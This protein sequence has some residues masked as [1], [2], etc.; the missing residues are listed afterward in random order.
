MRILTAVGTRP[1]LV[2][3]AP[4]S[5]ALRE[6]GHE[7]IL[8]HTGQHY[9]GALT[10]ILPEGAGLPAPAVSLGVGSGSHGA[11]VAAAARGIAEHAARLLPDAVLVAGDTN[12]ALAAALG[13]RAA[14]IPLVHGEA[15]VRLGS[16]ELP[17]EVNRIAADH[18]ADLLLAPTAR[19]AA[20][21]RAEKPRGRTVDAGDPLLDALGDVASRGEGTVAFEP[22]PGEFLLA[23]VHRA[24][25]TDRPGRLAAL[26][27]DLDALRFPVLL[28]LHPRT[29]EAMRAGGAA[30]AEGG[31]L[32]L[33][34]PMPHGALLGLARRARAVVTD[35]GGLQREAFWLGVPCVVLR[36]RCEWTETVEAGWAVLAGG[37]GA[38]LRAAVEAPPRGESAPDLGAFGGGTAASRWVRAMEEFLG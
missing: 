16:L 19:A 34:E 25:N 30:P 9:D 20:A 4:V 28:P 8:L 3:G 31:S 38:D 24:E 2:R 29:R 1:Q 10:A 21:A 13:A 37:G 22:P 5:R 11:Q 14:G 17:E 33:L 6:A 27:R 18:L 36:Y 35:S 12:S 32:R 15:G 23:T 26:L 7:E